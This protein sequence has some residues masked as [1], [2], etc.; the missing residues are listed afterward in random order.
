MA[1]KQTDTLV[2]IGVYV[3][4]HSHTVHTN[5]QAASIATNL[6]ITSCYAIIILHA[7][8]MDIF[9]EFVLFLL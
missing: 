5:W 7:T 1:T 4:M 6:S 3:F 8:I 9:C 2:C